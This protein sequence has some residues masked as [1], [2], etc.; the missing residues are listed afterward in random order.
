MKSEIS[1]SKSEEEEETLENYQDNNEVSIPTWLRFFE[2]FIICVYLLTSYF[3]INQIPIIYTS[4]FNDMII[5]VFN[6]N[7]NCV[8]YFNK[9]I[10]VNDGNKWLL[11]CYLNILEKW[12]L[13]DEEIQKDPS[14]SFFV[15]KAEI[16]I[17]DYNTTSC[18]GGEV[19]NLTFQ[20]DSNCQT[21]NRIPLSVRK[22]YFSS[23]FNLRILEDPLTAN[24]ITLGSL[25]YLMFSSVNLDTAS[26]ILIDDVSDVRNIK[27][28]LTT[29]YKLKATRIG[30]NID[31]LYA[32]KTQ[33]KVES[34]MDEISTNSEKSGVS[35]DIIDPNTRNMN[36]IVYFLSVIDGIDELQYLGIIVFNLQQNIDGTTQTS[37]NQNSVRINNIA[38]QG[39]FS[40]SEILSLLSVFGLLGSFYLKYGIIRNVEEILQRSFFFFV[41]FGFLIFEYIYKTN[42]IIKGIFNYKDIS[43]IN[44]YKYDITVFSIENIKIIKSFGIIFL[45]YHL[46]L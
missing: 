3:Y 29:S 46:I 45:C 4:H 16:H 31:Y 37:I 43:D 10:T 33:K 11:N 38:D 6:E 18:S 20:K 32:T 7:E 1:V 5:Q 15:H 23:N 35:Y 42:L 40:L 44:K 14:L 36:A 26:A 24:N 27:N 8:D 22:K 25:E 30:Q 28:L 13:S 17:Q 12:I 2:F 19:L 34:I 9:I 41:F 21:E 39:S